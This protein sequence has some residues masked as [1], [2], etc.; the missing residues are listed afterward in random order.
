MR[1]GRTSTTITSNPVRPHIP[2]T[3]PATPSPV[4]AGPPRSG[5]TLHDTHGVRRGAPAAGTD[6]VTSLTITATNTAGGADQAFTLTVNEAPAFTS[7][8]SGT[9]T[10]GTSGTFTVAATGFPAAVTYAVTA[11]TLPSGLTLNATSG[12]ISGTPAA[13]TGGVTSLTITATNT[14]GSTDQSFTLTVNELP[15]FTSAASATFTAGT[16]GTFTVAATGFPA[17]VTYAVTAGTLPSGLTPNTTAG[18]LSGPPAAGTGGANKRARLRAQ[19]QGKPARSPLAR[20]GFYT[21][22]APLTPAPPSGYVEGAPSEARA[23]TR[24]RTT[25]GGGRCTSKRVR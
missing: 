25:A 15:A 17:A 24:G 23:G 22:S 12:V 1:P 8:A 7:A 18:L 3:V 19:R 9:F 6:S 16:S 13:G 10:A 2:L 20:K 14:T 4:T 5:L 11:G 21:Y